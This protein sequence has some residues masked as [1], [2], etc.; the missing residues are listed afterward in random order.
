MR[1]ISS[2]AS[3]AVL[4]LVMV[5]YATPSAQGQVWH[6]ANVC[7]GKINAVDLMKRKRG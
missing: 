3:V 4:P 7:E 6:V 1:E 5:V 2:I